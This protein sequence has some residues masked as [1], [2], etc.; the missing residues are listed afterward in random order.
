MKEKSG[1]RGVGWPCTE[2]MCL[3]FHQPSAHHPCMAHLHGV[4]YRLGTLAQQILKHLFSMNTYTQ[5]QIHGQ[6][7][8]QE[9]RLMLKHSLMACNS[10][11]N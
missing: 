7:L 9:G 1:G 4:G 2:S 11:E 5:K 8:L 10:A 6:L 3:H